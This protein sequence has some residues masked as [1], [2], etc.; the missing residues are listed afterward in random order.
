VER[1]LADSRWIRTTFFFSVSVV[2]CRRVSTGGSIDVA[3]TVRFL[4]CACSTSDMTMLMTASLEND[5]PATPAPTGSE[6]KMN[7]NDV[8]NAPRANR[9]DVDGEPKDPGSPRFPQT[10]VATIQGPSTM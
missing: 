4:I 5:F 6:R 1:A 10:S 7:P 9:L 8:V 3:F 2:F